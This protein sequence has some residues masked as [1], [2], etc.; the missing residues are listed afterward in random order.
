MR[1]P[2]AFRIA[3]VLACA[4][5]VL[6]GQP[7]WKAANAEM[8]RWLKDHNE[9]LPEAEQITLSR[10]YDYMKTYW[11]NFKEYGSVADPPRATKK[12]KIPRHLALRAA[13][14]VK[15][16][17]WVTT[18]IRGKDFQYVSYYTSILQACE[19]CPELNQIMLQHGVTHAQLLEAMHQ[20][21]P[22]LVYRKV[23][24]KHTL[25]PSEL[26]QREAFA[27]NMLSQLAANPDIL[28]NTIYI[29]EASIVISKDTRSDVRVWCDKYDLSFTDVCPVPDHK[30]QPITVRWIC[31]VSSHP[32]FAA[33]GGLVY[34]EFTTGTTDIRRR[35]NTR[36]DGSTHVRDY[37][38]QVSQL[39]HPEHADAMLI[40]AAPAA[41]HTLLCNFH[42]RLKPL[43]AAVGLSSIRGGQH[44]A[45]TQSSSMQ[46]CKHHTLGVSAPQV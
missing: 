39:H 19:K 29:D 1:K 14:L 33:K 45:A 16:G 8:K 10:G 17:M 24:F 15:Q 25:T 40:S 23:F 5:V 13:N 44:Q 12:L 26:E 27:S 21:D 41:A 38:Y 42:I 28:P 2:L 32:A 20:A 35:V 30:G 34:F 37:Q 31:A 7:N 46:S 3:C 43:P 18:R 6:E 11:A 9:G 4:A 36:L 22:A